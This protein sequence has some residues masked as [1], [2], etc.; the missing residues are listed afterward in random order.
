MVVESKHLP[1]AGD[2]ENAFNLTPAELQQRKIIWIDIA[3][4]K[5]A[6]NPPHREPSTFLSEKTKRGNLSGEWWKGHD[7]I[8]CCY[9]LVNIKFQVF[10]LQ[11]RVEDVIMRV[12]LLL[13][14]S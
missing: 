8:M 5:I 1:D 2:T 11:G 14:N 12:S 4:D 9:K 6:D 7:P 13:K 3:G 10:G